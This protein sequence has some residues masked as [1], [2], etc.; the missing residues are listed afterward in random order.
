M[1]TK[2]SYKFHYKILKLYNKICSVQNKKYFRSKVKWVVTFVACSCFIHVRVNVFF[3][4]NG[5]P[6]V[7]SIH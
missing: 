6:H 7:M 4:S 5:S 2:C 1:Y 3:V